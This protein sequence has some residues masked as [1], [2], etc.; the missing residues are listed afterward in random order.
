MPQY[1]RGVDSNRCFR[2]VLLK[3]IFEFF[4]R[5]CGILG[6]PPWEKFVVF[7]CSLIYS[8]FHPHS[9]PSLCR[10]LHFFHR[11]LMFST[12]FLRKGGQCVGTHL[13]LN[14]KVHLHA[15]QHP[16]IKQNRSVLVMLILAS[17]PVFLFLSFS[18]QCY[19]KSRFKSLNIQGLSGIH[20]LI[21]L[22]FTTVTCFTADVPFV[23]F[24][25]QKQIHDIWQVL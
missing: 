7:N 12:V 23:L 20:L 22:L 14:V 2:C 15:A 11:R 1:L 4:A 5:V 18:S 9:S 3:L 17:F 21:L 24:G 13:L 10:V 19:K 8:L 25:T 16:V 6:F